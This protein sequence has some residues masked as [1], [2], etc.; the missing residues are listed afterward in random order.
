[1]DD[2]DP[3][4][5]MPARRRSRAVGTI[6]AL[7]GRHRGGR[8]SCVKHMARTARPSDDS[9]L[10]DRRRAGTGVDSDRGVER[11]G[12]GPAPYPFACPRT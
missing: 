8:R 4:R 9:G 6:P 10:L 3:A 7:T 11:P 2:D 12:L 1:M 5:R